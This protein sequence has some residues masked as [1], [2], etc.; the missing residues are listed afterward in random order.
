VLGGRAELICNGVDTDFFKPPSRLMLR[1]KTILAVGRF[2]EEQK[3]FSDLLRAV[4]E[5]PEFTL[6]L[7]GAGPQS[8][9]LKSLARKLGVSERVNFTGF[10]KDRTELRRLY[11]ESGVFVSTSSWEAVALVML[12]AMSCGSAVVG[13]RI[14]SFEELIADGKNG[15]LVPVGAP[16][17]VARAIREAF[18]RRALLG[19]N[20]R[21]TVL[22]R[23][24][25]QAVY[26]RLSDVIQ[27]V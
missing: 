15:L 18:D 12:E 7:V 17:E 3:R 10:I 4:A 16:R 21:S 9:M 8:Q 26:R 5:L 25:A 2:V 6:T 20:G 1:E 24:S 14:P 22:A 11:Q 23:Y 27:S 19:E 13:T